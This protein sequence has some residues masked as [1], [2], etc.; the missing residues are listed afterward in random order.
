MEPVVN[1]IERVFVTDVEFRWIDANSSDGQSIYRSF[2]LRG[3]PSYVI[4]NPENEVLW[5]GLGDQPMD[6]LIY[7]I[8]LALGE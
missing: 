4:L 6:N 3:H 7:Q 2:S 5:I 8:N 1:G